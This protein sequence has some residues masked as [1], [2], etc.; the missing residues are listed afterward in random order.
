MRTSWYLLAVTTLLTS[1]LSASTDSATISL[2]GTIPEVVTVELDAGSGINDLYLGENLTDIE[3]ARLTYTS[4]AKD[5]FTV[6]LTT[7]NDLTLI[8][9]GSAT[10]SVPYTLKYLSMAGTEKMIGKVGDPHDITYTNGTGALLEDQGTQSYAIFFHWR[11]LKLTYTL[12]SLMWEPQFLDTLTVT[13]C[14][15]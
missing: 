14:S 5:G 7:S 13:I 2:S 12:Q 8:G 11:T 10:Q 9:N 6:T 4:N 1:Y 3:V 15:K